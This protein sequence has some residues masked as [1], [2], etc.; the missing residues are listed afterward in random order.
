MLLFRSPLLPVLIPL[1][2]IGGATSTWS[3][4]P[5]VDFDTEVVPV[6]TRAGCN[7]GACHGGASGRGGLKL[8]LWGSDSAAD[9]DAIVREL[10]G[11]RVDLSDPGSSLVVAKPAGYRSH[12]GGVRLDD[13]EAKLFERWVAEGARRIERRELAGLDVEPSR[14]FLEEPDEEASLRVFARFDDGS[15]EDVTRRAVLASDDASVDIV[16]DPR[17]TVRPTRRTHA[18]VL[19]RFLGAIVPVEVIVPAKAKTVKSGSRAQR[20]D[21]AGPSDPVGPIDRFI[22]AKLEE[23]RLEPAPLAPDATFVRRVAL[24]IAGRLPTPREVQAFEADPSAER[25][26]TLVDHFLSDPSFVDWWSLRF[27]RLLRTR[28]LAS[29]SKAAASLYRF[30]RNEIAGDFRFDRFARA[31]LT[32]TGDSHEVGAAAFARMSPGPRE[33][34]EIVSRIFLGARLEC[35][36]CHDHPLDRF[37]QDDYHGFAAVFARLERGRVVRVGERGEVTHPKTGGAARP[38]IPGVRFLDA[39]ANDDPRVA[40]ADWLVSS[41]HLLFARAMVN[42]V[43]AELFGRGLVEPVDDLRPTNPASHPALLDALARDLIRDGFRLR[44]LI[45]RI[46]LSSAFARSSF[47]TPASSTEVGSSLASLET[48]FLARFPS[49]PLEA[50]ALLDAISAVTGVC[51]AFP[52]MPPGTRAVDVFDGAITTRSLELLGSSGAR[53]GGGATATGGLAVELHFLNGEVLNR[54]VQDADGRLAR[55]LGEGREPLSIVAEL[56]RVALAR[57]PSNRER[58]LFENA[59]ANAADASETRAILEDI[60]WSVLRSQEFG[61]IR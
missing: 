25:R 8:S 58:E 3:A 39:N 51:E 36:N 54:R 59:L 57:P 32:A 10:E 31:L 33:D 1:A 30:I 34:A 14:I 12:G 21:P 37:T 22:D 35:A 13:E 6:L 28:S 55:A 38:R 9:Y 26:A 60:L 50:E 53:G 29:D 18:T 16:D 20:I 42:R 52:G 5:P 19:V 23:L 27:A 43:W 7:S 40:F 4:P 41:D 17:G 11:R 46:A 48:R 15:R 2:L 56:Y 61:T 44:P 24:A 47:P 49:R 45:R